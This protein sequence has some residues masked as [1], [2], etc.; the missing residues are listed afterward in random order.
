MSNVEP[1]GEGVSEKKIDYGPGYR[2]YFGQDGRDLIVLLGGG[3][4]KGQQ[5]D[6]RAAKELWKD[7]KARKRLQQKKEK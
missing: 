6:I 1:V 4:K 5:A 2:I 3:S 7:Y